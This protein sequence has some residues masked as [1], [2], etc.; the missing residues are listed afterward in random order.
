MRTGNIAVNA[1]ESVSSEPGSNG[2]AHLLEAV[3]TERQKLAVSWYFAPFVTYPSTT[4]G[5]TILETIATPGELRERPD[6]THC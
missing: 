1:G 6:R 5:C 4:G 3:G 2:P